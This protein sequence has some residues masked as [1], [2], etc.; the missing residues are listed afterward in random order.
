MPCAP[1]RCKSRASPRS[2]KL[3][4]GRRRS[5]T[6]LI[7]DC[8]HS[9]GTLD[10]KSFNGNESR[11]KVHMYPLCCLHM[12]LVVVSKCLHTLQTFGILQRPQSSHSATLS[13]SAR[14]SHSAHF[15][16][17]I[18]FT[19]QT[20]HILLALSNL[21][22]LPTLQTSSHS[23]I[24]LTLCC[25]FNFHILRRPTRWVWCMFLHQLHTEAHKVGLVYVFATV[26]T[27]WSSTKTSAD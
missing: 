15:S 26:Y 23:A 14:T 27:L 19:L 8:M 24:L 2:A 10:E 20:R 5:Q 3:P 6:N 11:Q 13:L 25:F 4:D 18:F 1:A 16:R 22:A 21:Q 12:P 9:H 7:H 17:W